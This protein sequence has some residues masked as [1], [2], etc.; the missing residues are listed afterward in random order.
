[1]YGLRNEYIAIL[2][3]NDS[4]CLKVMCIF[5]CVIFILKE[6]RIYIRQRG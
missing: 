2:I 4:A 3:N 6:I 5:V 1:M